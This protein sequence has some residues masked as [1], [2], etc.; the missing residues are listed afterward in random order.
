MNPPTGPI[1]SVRDVT[2]AFDDASSC[3][4]STSSVNP[5]TI[6]GVIGPSGAGKTTTIRMLTG[7]LAPNDGD[8][9]RARRGPDALPPPDARAD[10]LHAPAVQPLR[11]PD[12]AARTST[13]WQP[14]RH[15][16]PAGGRPSPRGA[17]GSSTCGTPATAAPRDLSGGMQRRLELACAL[18]HEPGRAVPRRADRRHRPDPARDDLGR[19]AS[20]ARRGP[21]AARHDAVRQRGGG[22]RPGRA[23]RRRA[24]SS[25]SPRRTSCAGWRSAA[26]S[27]RSDR[28]GRST[29]DLLASVA[30][31]QDVRQ[32]GPRNA[33]CDRLRRAVP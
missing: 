5:G 23:D 20:P 13:S 11:G 19:A 27:S 1:I 25:P 7:A 30:G 26:T 15:L 22:V 31:V 12:G 10:R 21:D 16:C 4:T 6:L 2:R 24:S 9:P 8:D 28:R 18:V 32:P 17:R 33:D 29:P 14:V 3:T